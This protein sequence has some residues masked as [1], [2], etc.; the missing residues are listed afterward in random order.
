M[1]KEMKTTA[2]YRGQKHIHT[3]NQFRK[4]TMKNTVR[5]NNLQNHFHNTDCTKQSEFFSQRNKEGKRIK[6]IRKIKTK[7]KTKRKIERRIIINTL[8]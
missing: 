7:M 3:H 8:N 4:I 2:N 1:N 6:K 5:A